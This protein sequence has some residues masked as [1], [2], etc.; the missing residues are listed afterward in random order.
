MHFQRQEVAH[1]VE[2]E[3]T[4][5]L[6]EDELIAQPLKHLAMNQGVSPL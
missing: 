1:L 3:L 4:G 2:P 5:T 6:D